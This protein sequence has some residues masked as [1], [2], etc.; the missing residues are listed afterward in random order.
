MQP[1]DSGSSR[2]EAITPP[3]SNVRINSIHVIASSPVLQVKQ[4]RANFIFAKRIVT[5]RSV[6]IDDVTFADI[7]QDRLSRAQRCFDNR[8]ELH[9]TVADV[10][11]SVLS[12]KTRR[13]GGR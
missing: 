8:W 9:V 5:A 12:H 2:G 1:V 10:G 4:L 3:L 7:L 13:R 6:E 11:Q